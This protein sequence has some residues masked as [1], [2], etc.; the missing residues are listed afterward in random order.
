M[1]IETSNLSA[2]SLT[3]SLNGTASFSDETTLAQ[4]SIIANSTQHARNLENRQYVVAANN[5]AMLVGPIDVT[6]MIE[7]QTNGNLIIL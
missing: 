3:G 5:N 1:A 7:I 6:D 4:T 2:T